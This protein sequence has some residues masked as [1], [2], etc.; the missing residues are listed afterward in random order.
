MRSTFQV[1]NEP[2]MPTINTSSCRDSSGRVVPVVDRNRCE[3]KEECVRVC[4]YGVFSIQ[5]WLR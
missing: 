2:R 3:G 5:S 4:P 1:D